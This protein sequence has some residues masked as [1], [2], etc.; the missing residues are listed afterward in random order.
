L[1]KIANALGKYAQERKAA[2]LP[3]LTRADLNVLLNYNRETGHLLNYDNETGQVGN[4]SM[5]VL[6]N[7]GTI[8]R[9]LDNKLIFPGGKLTPKGLQECERLQQLMPAEATPETD[10]DK[11]VEKPDDPTEAAASLNKLETQNRT[12]PPQPAS[13]P[14]AVIQ[15]ELRDKTQAP[16]AEAT[17]SSPEKPLPQAKIPPISPKQE[18]KAIEP[19]LSEESVNSSVQSP[20]KR[21]TSV[22]Q[23]GQETVLIDAEEDKAV[24]ND[25]KRMAKLSASTANKAEKPGAYYKRPVP[26]PAPKFDKKALD[27]NLISLHDPQSYEAEQFKIL[28]T[29]ILFPVSGK[30]PKSILVTSSLPAEGKSFVSANLAISIALNINKHVLLMDCDI[31]KPDLHR[32]FGFGEL[33]G[34]SDYLI[35]RQ[36][37]A[38]LLIRTHVDKLSL[39]P[40]GP[41]PSNPS[42]LM[43][44]ERMSA[45][46]QEVKS[47][48][49]DRLI[50]IDSPPPG[51][52]AET[53]FLAREVDGII[54]V[55]KHLKTPRQEVEDLM[56]TVGSDKIIGCVVNQLDTT[57][58]RYYGYKKYGG[59]GKR[60]QR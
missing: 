19:Q 44:S 32:M 8:Q 29:N 45:L 43:S 52:A 12:I 53:A 37:L 9:L 21:K 10:G 54:I 22:R 33:A 38:S 41:V 47:R 40:S 18:T 34:L 35:E 6:R 28:R 5:E 27:R 26:A 3:G 57:M 17:A 59:Y 2:R 42:E 39:L 24:T 15:T 58:S 4:P 46:L 36:E 11:I 60:Y 55:V 14:P 31:R 48:Y 25:D 16:A 7:K 49:E 56:E 51:L 1:G 20:V 13:Q 30:V 50:V 23:L